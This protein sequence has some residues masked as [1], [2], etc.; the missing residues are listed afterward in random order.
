MELAHLKRITAFQPVPEPRGVARSVR[1]SERNRHGLETRDTAERCARRRICKTNPRRC[2]GVRAHTNAQNNA[3]AVQRVCVG[4]VRRD[5]TM[6]SQKVGK[7]SQLP[8]GTWD[9]R[10]PAAAC[11]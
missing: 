9:G 3:T 4:R 5:K 1:S 7:K 11:L 8:T 6:P 10:N 2:A